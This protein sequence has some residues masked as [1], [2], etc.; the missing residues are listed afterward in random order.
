MNYTQEWRFHS[1]LEL[2][3]EKKKKN[4]FSCQLFNVLMRL[5]YNVAALKVE[6]GCK[7]MLNHEHND[8]YRR[9]KQRN[10][11]SS[12]F[13]SITQIL[14]TAPDPIG[15]N[16]IAHVAPR[17]FFGDQTFS[18]CNRKT[19]SKD[20]YIYIYLKKYPN[21]IKRS[22]RLLICCCGY[23]KMS[24]IVQMSFVLFPFLC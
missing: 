10:K 3:P 14:G 15:V 5:S 20:T 13:C 17:A 7:R 4:T 24:G 19:Q 22:H 23:D 12:V 11:N 6:Q 16:P 21:C 2:L 8:G 9:H 18:H 1:T